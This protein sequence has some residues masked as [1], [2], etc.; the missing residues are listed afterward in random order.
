MLEHSK[1]KLSTKITKNLL[2][3]VR[4]NYN[5]IRDNDTSVQWQTS[6]NICNSKLDVTLNITSS[7]SIDITDFKLSKSIISMKANNLEK[8]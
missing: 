8:Y 3:I 5:I 6:D 7:V 4:D 2:I 1:I